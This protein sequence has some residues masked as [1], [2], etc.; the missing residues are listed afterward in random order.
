[1]FQ[2]TWSRSYLLIV[3]ARGER[4]HAVV[5][6]QREHVVRPVGD[7]HVTQLTVGS[8]GVG[9]RRDDLADATTSRHVLRDV[10]RVGRALE[11][12]RVVVGVGDLGKK[13][14]PRLLVDATYRQNLDVVDVAKVRAPS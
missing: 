4:E 3:E 6:V 5:R 9:V 12:R 10:E 14:S 1:M 7:Q 2:I 8:F 13:K 11:G